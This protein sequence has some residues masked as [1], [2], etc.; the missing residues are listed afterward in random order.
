[1]MV[2]VNSPKSMLELEVLNVWSPRLAAF[3]IIFSYSFVT[4]GELS[5]VFETSDQTR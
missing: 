2:S 1:M 5:F 4:K 3:G